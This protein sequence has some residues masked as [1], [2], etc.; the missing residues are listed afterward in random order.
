MKEHIRMRMPKDLDRSEWLK[1]HDGL[2]KAIGIPFVT[3]P[4]GYEHPDGE[5]LATAGANMPSSLKTTIM[6]AMEIYTGG[7]E[8]KETFLSPHCEDDAD[9]FLEGRHAWERL[10][11]GDSLHSPRER[12]D[13]ENAIA[14]S[15]IVSDYICCNI[16][17]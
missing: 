1:G 10:Y 9:D 5:W 6:L 2:A 16:R 17:Y 11:R 7:S 3:T 13:S 4:E 8:W 12:L 14:F 15:A